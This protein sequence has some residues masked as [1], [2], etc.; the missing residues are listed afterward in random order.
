MKE[1]AH[2]TTPQAQA[3]LAA[4]I[5]NLEGLEAFS[6]GSCPGCEECGGESDEP[7]FSNSECDSCRSSL[8]GDRHPAHFLYQG[9]VQH[10]TV[11]S[12]C[13]MYHANGDLPE[14]WEG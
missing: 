12:D 10:C 1:H 7:S 14:A 6:V 9:E 11:C 13:L 4:V 2:Q 8:G 5:K 3:F